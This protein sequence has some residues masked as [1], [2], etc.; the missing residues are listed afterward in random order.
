MPLDNIAIVDG[1]KHNLLSI[2]QLCEKWHQVWF[3]TEVYV[4]SNKKKIKMVLTRNIKRNVYIA[5]FNS[6]STYSITYL[7]SKANIYMRVRCGIRN[8]LI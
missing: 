5:D 7:F 2:I 4:V 3:S 6:T 8:C 1:L